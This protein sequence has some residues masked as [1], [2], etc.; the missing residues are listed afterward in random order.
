MK[1]Y[2][3]LDF[4]IDLPDDVISRIEVRPKISFPHQSVHSKL[5]LI[6]V[7]SQL[8]LVRMTSASSR[9]PF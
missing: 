8:A 7:L 6:V 3:L 5:N 2:S 1:Y 4:L 9:F